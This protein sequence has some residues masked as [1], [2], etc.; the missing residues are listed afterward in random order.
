MQTPDFYELFG[1]LVKKKRKKRGWTQEEAADQILGNINKNPEISL[2]EKGGRNL[3]DWNI[4]RYRDALDISAE[5]LASLKNRRYR[6]PPQDEFPFKSFGKLE[7][8]VAYIFGDPEEPYSLED[9]VVTMKDE[10]FHETEQFPSAI[11]AELPEL[12]EIFYCSIPD[13]TV[14]K[15]NEMPRMDDFSQEGESQENERGR[16]ILKLSKTRF[17][18]YCATN[19]SLEKDM[20]QSDDRK[21]TVREVLA[22]EPLE[23]TNSLLGNP[24]STHVSIISVNPKQKPREQ[25][26]VLRRKANSP[27]Y[28]RFYQSVAGYG[29]LAHVDTNGVPSPFA[30]AVDESKEEFS[31]NL[32]IH[33][34]G[35][36]ITGLCMS[37]EDLDLNFCS[38]FVTNQTA[39][40]ILNSTRRD[41]FEG[42]RSFIPWHPKS[43]I[44]H[45]VR[46]KW[47]P[48]GAYN[49]IMSLIAYFGD[50]AVNTAVASCKRK[51]WFDFLEHDV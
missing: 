33:I 32:D 34:E 25:V 51:P 13:R 19:R 20:Y 45:I 36:K 43:V 14:I 30:T 1:R 50:D 42:Q 38:Y 17:V 11:K 22:P 15:D 41:A 31:K 35:V 10:I 2:V 5:E 44:D 49:M 9:F 26:S 3:E 16:V 39:Q 28:P 23:L 6:R 21:D 27:I 37:N 29:S 40:S 24:Y 8:P 7:L 12:E 48:V 18:H 47:E 46:N 4:R